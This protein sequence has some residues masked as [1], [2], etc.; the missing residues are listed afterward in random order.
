MSLPRFFHKRGWH[1]SGGRDGS[2]YL[3]IFVLV[4]PVKEKAIICLKNRQNNNSLSEQLLLWPH[5]R[6]SFMAELGR[7]GTSA[8]NAQ[9]RFV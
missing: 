6:A 4:S 7:G 5:A 1:N 9:S 3:C 8:W 2:M